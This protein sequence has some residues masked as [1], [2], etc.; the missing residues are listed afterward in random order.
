MADIRPFRA[1]RYDPARV[2]GLGAV[3]GPPE[4][5]PSAEHARAIAEGHPYHPVR[6]EM[7]DVPA[8]AS[9]AGAGRLLRQWLR[10]GVLVRDHRPAVYVYEQEYAYGDERRNRCG[11]FATLPLSEPEAGVVL[12]HERVLPQNLDL[13]IE[14]L[15]DIRANLSAVYL[16]IKDDGWI[17]RTL[18]EIVANPP[19]LSGEDDEG[20]VHRLWVVDDPQ[21]IREL[22]E[23]AAGQPLYIAD[24]HHRYAAALAYRDELR[25]RHGQAGRADDVLVYVADVA[26][27]G[28]LVLPI[29]RVVGALGG[30]AW[31]EVVARLERYFD[32]QQCPFTSL[33]SRCTLET[34]VSRLARA[35]G[36]PTY[37][38]LGAGGEALVE[39][40]LRDWAAIE[41]LLPPEVSPLTRRLDVT[42][43]DA[44]VL[45]QVLGIEPAE[46]EQRV[47][48]TPDVAQA[49]R[50]V[51][52]GEAAL[53]AFVR[54]TP[55]AAL[56]AVARA[57]ERMPQKSTYFYPKV[58]IGLVIHDFD[59]ERS[60]KA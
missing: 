43:L 48:F 52:D 22:R 27:P 26:D 46:V 33:A 32:L 11:F 28:I 13:R 31:G 1:V 45:R 39:A 24:G 51:G 38:L 14:L 8:D 55:L 16:L 57:G 5:I 6:L 19:D 35:D 23:A 58:P 34:A 50:A 20:G 37:L 56:L 18:A 59:D 29:H 49:A 2:G 25:Q 40:R 54:P 44:V 10:E 36:P 4:D 41:P 12:P 7:H 3:M 30:L 21:A 47:E 42:V 53:A 15:R 9:F 17:G 60:G